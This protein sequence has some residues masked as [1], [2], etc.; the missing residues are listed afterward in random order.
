VLLHRIDSKLGR[1]SDLEGA[2]APDGRT[3]RGTWQNFILSGGEPTSGQW[4]AKKKQEKG[5]P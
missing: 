3:L 4:V 2:L 5:E 1:S